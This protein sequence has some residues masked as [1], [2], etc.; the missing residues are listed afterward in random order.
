MPWSPAQTPPL[1]L[2]MRFDLPAFFLDSSHIPA[3]LSMSESQAR[4]KSS[5]CLVSRNE[6]HLASKIKEKASLASLYEIKYVRA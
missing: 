5:A 1:S 3:L 2:L 6:N 4:K